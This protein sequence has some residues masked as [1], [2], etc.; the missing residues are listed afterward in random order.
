[1]VYSG[2]PRPGISALHPNLYFAKLR[3]DTRYQ[4]YDSTMII[5][6]SP[7]DVWYQSSPLLAMDL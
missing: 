7:P 4:R 2:L 6:S 1:M 5:M 3:N